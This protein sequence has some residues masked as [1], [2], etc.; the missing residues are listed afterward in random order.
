MYRA[1]QLCMSFKA[2]E[3]IVRTICSITPQQTSRAEALSSVCVEDT[4]KRVRGALVGTPPLLLL[5]LLVRSGASVS[6]Q[7]R[8]QKRWAWWVI[9]T[10]K[11][12]NDNITIIITTIIIMKRLINQLGTVMRH[13]CASISAR[14][15]AWVITCCAYASTCCT[16]TSLAPAGSTTAPAIRREISTLKLLPLVLLRA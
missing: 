1:Y 2:L 7:K 10:I 4:T 16:R 8:Q 15:W 5:L 11:K 6:K 3:S 12:N 14:E 9:V 13:V